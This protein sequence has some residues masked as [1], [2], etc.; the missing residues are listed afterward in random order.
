ML[1]LPTRS[2]LSRSRRLIEGRPDQCRNPD[3]RRHRDAAALGR[4]THCGAPSTKLATVGAAEWVGV[5]LEEGLYED[6]VTLRIRERVDQLVAQGRA[7]LLV[8]S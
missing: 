1:R 5:G 8:S 3:G 7:A 2:E 6:L 4:K